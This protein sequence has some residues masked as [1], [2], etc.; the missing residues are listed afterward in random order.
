MG[1]VE[2]AGNYGVVLPLV[3]ESL[4]ITYRTALSNMVKKSKQIFDNK[5]LVVQCPHM[6]NQSAL[7]MQ[8]PAISRPFQAVG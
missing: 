7:R 2:L 8:L 3:I 4:S 1:K 5:M 6:M